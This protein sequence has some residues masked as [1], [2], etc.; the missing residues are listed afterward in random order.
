MEDS[1]ML[2]ARFYF[3]Y[4]AAAEAAGLYDK[5]AELFK[6]SIA[7]DPG[8][9]ADACNYLAYMWADRNSHLDEAEDL[10]GRALKIDPDNGAYLDT[11][12]W[13]EF[14]H[15]RFESALNTLLRAAE[16]LSR[17]DPVVFEHLGDTYSKLNRIPQAIESWQKALMLD[18]QNKRLS[19]K[20]DTTKPK[21]S[22]SQLRN[23]I[24]VQ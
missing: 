3:D 23:E 2:N 12:G 6:K 22:K 14:R 17:D 16:H 21:L 1:E 15:G 19:D 4:G 20:I 10:I 8:N 11:L 5:A 24:P 9:A 18:P 13:L 7:L